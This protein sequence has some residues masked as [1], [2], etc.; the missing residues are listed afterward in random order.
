VGFVGVV[1]ALAQEKLPADEILSGVAADL[2]DLP[3]D[4][5]EEAGTVRVLLRRQGRRGGQG[6]KGR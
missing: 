6:E 2:A 5:P 3:M 4:L 1:V